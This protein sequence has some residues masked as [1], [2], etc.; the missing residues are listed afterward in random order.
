MKFE[1]LTLVSG[2]VGVTFYLLAF[3]NEYWHTESSDIN[4]SQYDWVRQTCGKF[5]HT[6]KYCNADSDSS[7]EDSQSESESDSDISTHPESSQNDKLKT[8][9]T[10]A[11]DAENKTPSFN[12]NKQTSNAADKHVINNLDDQSN[13][14]EKKAK[15]HVKKLNGQKTVRAQT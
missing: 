2:I 15:R 8:T 7:S 10:Q 14:S 1:V 5:G 12:F 13:Q 3:V 11:A 6:A 9:L 4:L